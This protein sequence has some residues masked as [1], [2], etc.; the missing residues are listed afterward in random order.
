MELASLE[1][2]PQKEVAVKVA[3]VG[4]NFRDVL[5]VLGAYPDAHGLPGDDSG[6]HVLSEAAEILVRESDLT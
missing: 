4:L 1:I 6:G 3:A 5:M 2:E